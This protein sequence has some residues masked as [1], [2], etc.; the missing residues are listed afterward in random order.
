MQSSMDTEW[1]TD[2]SARHLASLIRAS[3]GHGWDHLSDAMR[4][5]VYD[6]M[7]LRTFINNTEPV[8]MEIIRAI[9]DALRKLI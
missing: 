7:I 5:D 9:R 4:D 8:R 2:A 3:W 1:N 6:A